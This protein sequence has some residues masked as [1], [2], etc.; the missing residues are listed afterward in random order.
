VS[1]AIHQYDTFRTMLQRELGL[2]P[3]PRLA[4][5]LPAAARRVDMVVT[6]RGE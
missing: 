3:S 6:G 4:E 5:L 2:E 1:D